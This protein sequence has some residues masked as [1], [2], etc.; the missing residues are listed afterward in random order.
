[1]KDKERETAGK[2]YK[3]AFGVPYSNAK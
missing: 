3:S 1:M 2:K